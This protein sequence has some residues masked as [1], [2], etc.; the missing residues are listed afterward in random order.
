MRGG[1][2]PIINQEARMTVEEKRIA[3]R[4]RQRKFLEEH[5]E[6]VN[7]KRRERYEERKEERKCPR[8]GKTLRK[9]YTKIMCKECLEI[10]RE[11]IER[12]VAAKR[13]AA[14]KASRK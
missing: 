6:E 4:M 13:K 3:N 5:R 8:C 9:T 11:G 7:A 10:S 14:K 1:K 12:R 2:Q